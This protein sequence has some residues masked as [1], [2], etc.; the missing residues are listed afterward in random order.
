[1]T[2]TATGTGMAGM[3]GTL[4]DD[5]NLGW[6]QDGEPLLHFFDSVHGNVFLNGRTLT[7]A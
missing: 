3:L 1:M 2:T 6:M 5:V 7:R 4:V